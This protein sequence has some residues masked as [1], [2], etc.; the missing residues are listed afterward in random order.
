MT[1][2]SMEDLKESYARHRSVRIAFIAAVA[3]VA[4]I[5]VF[6]SLTI[7]TRS[8]DITYV[9]DLVLDHISGATYDRNLQYGLWYDDIIVWDYRLPRAIFALVA[10][11]GLAVAGAAMQSVMKNPLADPYTT[12][13]SSGALLGVAIAMVFGFAAG[14]GGIDGYG[15]IVNAMIFS[16]IPWWSY[17]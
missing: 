5:L 3:V 13:I 1:M 15:T 9:Y 10:G 8:L 6:V 14:A 4:V 12:G 11:A 17:I 2:R 7:G 16:M